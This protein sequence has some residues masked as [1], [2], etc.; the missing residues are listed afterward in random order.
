MLHLGG[1]PY[2]R[3]GGKVLRG[4]GERKPDYTQTHEQAYHSD[5]V[6]LGRRWLCRR[7]L[8]KR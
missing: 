2:R 5:N 6:A 3:L 4:D 7:R 8:S 1:E